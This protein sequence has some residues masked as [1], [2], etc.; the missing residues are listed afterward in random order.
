MHNTYSHSLLL[1]I[2]RHTKSALTY[3]LHQRSLCIY[4]TRIFFEL[5]KLVLVYMYIQVC[6][7][8]S[9]PLSGLHL[10]PCTG[11]HLH[12]L[13]MLTTFSRGARVWLGGSNAPH[14]PNETLLIVYH[15][16]DS[17]KYTYIHGH[18]CTN[19]IHVYM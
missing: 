7:S 4:N 10:E 3:M 19:S 12:P 5:Q 1:R 15:T 11:G 17:Y 16:P 14:P 9:H 13:Y 2:G 6:I 8:P 18:T